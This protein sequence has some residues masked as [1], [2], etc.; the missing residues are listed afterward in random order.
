MKEKK[1][2]ENERGGKK[3]KEELGIPA[4]LNRH[5]KMLRSPLP[6]FHVYASTSTFTEST[7]S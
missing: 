4:M 3:E 7:P 5:R 6:R 2:N 1:R